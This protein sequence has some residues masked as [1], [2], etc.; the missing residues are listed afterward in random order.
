MIFTTALAAV[1]AFVPST[2]SAAHVWKSQRSSS[3]IHARD[4]AITYTIAQNYSGPT[5]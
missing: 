4:D 5:L 3:S 1:A 2:V